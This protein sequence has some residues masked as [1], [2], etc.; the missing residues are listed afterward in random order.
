[1]DAIGIKKNDARALAT[2]LNDFDHVR[3]LFFW[4]LDRPWNGTLR[5][6]GLSTSRLTCR[7]VWLDCIEN[8]IIS[9]RHELLAYAVGLIKKNQLVAHTHDFLDAPPKYR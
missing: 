6:I 9:G 8:G 7:Q 4:H 5:G 1:M 2:L 3:H